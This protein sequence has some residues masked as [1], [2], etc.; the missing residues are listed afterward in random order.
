MVAG[1]PVK[2][3]VV[4]LGSMG[5]GVARALL[6]AGLE[7]H[8]FDVRT[9][10]LAALGAAGG[11]P[12]ATPAAAGGRVDAL[13]VLVVNAE[14]T[15][16]A[17]FG[18]DGAAPALRKGAVVLTS[19]TVAPEYAAALG[20]RL[21][22]AGLLHLDAPVSGGAGKAAAG[23]L[24]VMAS[25]APAAFDAARPV[26]DAMAAK[27]HRLGDRSGQGSK[28]KVVNQLL[29]GVH[30]AAAAEAM[31]LCIKEG[32][33]PAVVYD[34]ICG[35]AGSSWMFQNRVPH[36]LAGDYTPL[37]AVSIFVKDLG[38]VLDSG[39]KLGMPL[40]LTSAAHQ[41]FLLAAAAGH[42]AED[43]SAVVKI[44]PGVALPGPRHGE[45]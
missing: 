16:A 31:A 37:S 34:V 42:A 27:V 32:A 39:R 9:E 38:I 1:H 5:L 20:D 18:P 36:I 21:A 33:D 30:I 40:P 24:T 35:S 23:Q 28:V 11:V 14:Q 44:F 29:A 6:R 3:G 17:L 22:A 8:G 13:V 45:E 26:L 43:D 41:M 15:E 19:A 4:G 7:V 12:A 10:A 2:V 25:G